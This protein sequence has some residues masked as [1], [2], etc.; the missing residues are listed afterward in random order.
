MISVRENRLL[1]V[2]Q[3]CH[4][5][6][7]H[8][9]QQQHHRAI[10]DYLLALEVVEEWGTPQMAAALLDCL[11]SIYQQIG[12]FARALAFYRRTVALLP[13]SD[14]GLRLVALQHIHQANQK[15]KEKRSQ[16]WLSVAPR[17]AGET[18]TA[19]I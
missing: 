19:C 8:L 5:A 7:A 14:G 15:M 6:E 9:Q 4:Q 2:Q 12:L 17:I 10:A 16:P 11:G 13:E 3:L 1:K 18:L